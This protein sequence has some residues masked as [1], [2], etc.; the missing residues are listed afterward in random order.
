MTSEQISSPRMS[1][2]LKVVH[3][4][5]YW[6][7]GEIQ[8]RKDVKHLNRKGTPASSR[9]YLLNS[10]VPDLWDQFRDSV[11]NPD[12]NLAPAIQKLQVAQNILGACASSQ[13]AYIWD[14]VDRGRDLEIARGYSQVAIE[15]FEQQWRASPR[16]PKTNLLSM[17]VKEA[18]TA[19]EGEGAYLRPVS[20]FRSLIALS[21]LAITK[22]ASD[23]IGPLLP[24][25]GADS[26]V[27]NQ[28][29]HE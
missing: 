12:N 18:V 11:K 21:A 2:Q 16:L 3:A 10:E 22:E 25:P 8:H 7:N 5:Q 4:I 29:R 9:N 23:S 1:R 15:M 24:E 6:L 26:G 28:W 14:Q 13:V 17:P 19:F 20:A 27:L